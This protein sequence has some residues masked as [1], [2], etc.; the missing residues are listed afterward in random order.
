MLTED[1]NYFLP[2]N[3]IAQKPIRPRDHSRLMILNREKKSISHDFFYNLTKYLNPGDILVNNNSKVIPARLMGEKT[4]KGKIECL[5][6]KRIN[7]DT[8]EVMIKGKVKRDQEIKFKKGLK[9]KII[10]KTSEQTWLIKFNLSATRLDKKIDKTGL[11]PTPPYIKRISNLKEYQTV[12]AKNNGSAAAPTAGFHFT[13]SLIKKIEKQNIQI[14]SITLHVGLGTFQPIRAERIENHKIHSEWAKI[15]PQT[16]NFLNKTKKNKQKIVAIGTTT[17]RALESFNNNGV[18]ESGEKWVKNFIYPGYQFKS[19]DALITNFHLPKSSLLIMVS[20]FA[21]KN[22]IDKAY[23][24]A[25]KEKYRF[26]SFGD[27]MLII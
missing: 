11:T 21:N 10:E 5:L 27:A 26:Y 15:S 3:L 23:Q 13:K 24:E 6:L 16:A 1:F 19:I 12:W 14:K 17:T 25:I 2:K 9:G 22:F 8:Y 20:A 4:T 7:K 18:I